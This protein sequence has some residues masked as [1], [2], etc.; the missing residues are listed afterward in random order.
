VGLLAGFAA[1][2]G[3]ADEEEVWLAQNL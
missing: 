2:H 1:W 3:F